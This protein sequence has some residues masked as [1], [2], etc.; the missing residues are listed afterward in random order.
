VGIIGWQGWRYYQNSQSSQAGVLYTAIEQALPKNESAPA[1]DAAEQLAS[2]F[3]STSYAPRGMLL[4][5]KLAF[6]AGDHATAKKRYQW[7]IDHA[8]EDGLKQVARLRLATVLLDEK[9]YDQALQTLDAK[10]DEA[11]DGLYADLKGDILVAAGKNAEAKIAYQ[12]ALS[13]IDAK[14]P[15]RNYLQVKLEALGGGAP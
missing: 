12:T 9:Q 5:A 11:V 4:A 7:V 2:K 15:Y 13:K 1:Q 10:H 3:G 14:S 6:D 8:G